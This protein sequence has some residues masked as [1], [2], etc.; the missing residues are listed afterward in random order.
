MPWTP[1]DGLEKRK[2]DVLSL[3][4]FLLGRCTRLIEMLTNRLSVDM[5]FTMAKGRSVLTAF[6]SHNLS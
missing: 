6:V 4:C 3:T 1:G 5:P 2:G